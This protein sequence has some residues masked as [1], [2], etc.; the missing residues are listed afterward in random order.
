MFRKIFRKKTLILVMLVNGVCIAAIL[1]ITYVA[2]GYGW[3]QSFVGN[4]IGWII[5]LFIAD[6]FI[7]KI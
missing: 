5:G 3:I 4:T 2:F 1:S 7:R 6:K